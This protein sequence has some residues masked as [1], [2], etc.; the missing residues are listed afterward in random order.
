MLT[1]S[2][3]NLATTRKKWFVVQEGVWMHSVTCHVWYVLGLLMLHSSWKPLPYSL[4]IGS[5]G[6]RGRKEQPQTVLSSQ[7]FTFAENSVSEHHCGFH[8]GIYVLLL[9]SNLKKQNLESQ[10]RNYRSRWYPPKKRCVNPSLL[11]ITEEAQI[12]HVPA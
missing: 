12:T 9:G 8:T 6:C 5:K 4:A 2:S 7:N 10:W 11:I 1:S 3:T